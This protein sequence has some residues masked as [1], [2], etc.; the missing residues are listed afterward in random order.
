MIIETTSKDTDGPR[1]PAEAYGML[2]SEGMKFVRGYSGIMPMLQSPGKAEVARIAQNLSDIVCC[3]AV[4]SEGYGW[5]SVGNGFIFTA[6]IYS[7]QAHRAPFGK[8]NFEQEYLGERLV[9]PLEAKMEAQKA[10]ADM[11]CATSGKLRRQVAATIVRGSESLI[12]Q[13]GN[14]RVAYDLVAYMAGPK[15]AFSVGGTPEEISRQAKIIDSCVVSSFLENGK[16]EEKFLGYDGKKYVLLKEKTGLNVYELKPLSRVEKALIPVCMEIIKKCVEHDDLST[17]G[18]IAGNRRLCAAVR[19][20]AAF[21][22]EQKRV[23]SRTDIEAKMA[24]SPLGKETSFAYLTGRSKLAQAF[25]Q[26]QGQRP[27][28]TWRLA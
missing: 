23:P 14:A 22:L 21:A 7:A 11:L 27:R 9:F 20:S 26:A 4:S 18:K 24:F 3:R 16:A 10:L 28:V 6:E 2:V 15:F 25:P 17:L 5:P 19:E 1:E 13:Y 12:K 8:M